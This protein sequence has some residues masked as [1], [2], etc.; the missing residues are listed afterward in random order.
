MDAIDLS[1]LVDSVVTT[2]EGDTTS[3][4]PTNPLDGWDTDKA[5]RKVD[6]EL[7]GKHN[8]PD[9]LAEF[10]RTVSDRVQHLPEVASYASIAHFRAKRLQKL[11]E[12]QGTVLG[13]MVSNLERVISAL[14]DGPRKLRLQ[15]LLY[16][17]AGVFY[18]AIGNFDL[19]AHMHRRSATIAECFGDKAGSAIGQFNGELCQLREDVAD[20][21]ATSVLEDTYSHLKEAFD[22]LRQAVAGTPMELRWGRANAP[23]LMLQ[24]IVWLNAIDPGL[25]WWDAAGCDQWFESFFG[26][27]SELGD[28][29][30]DAVRLVSALDNTYKNSDEADNALSLIINSNAA[31]EIR[32]TASLAIIWHR[33]R[34]GQDVQPALKTLLDMPSGVKHVKAAANCLLNRN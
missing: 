13:Q 25:A 15:S 32:A 4:D 27:C 2:A 29:F 31:L 10:A 3:P 21:E 30:S 26:A 1:S 18:E 28:A 11:T 6:S 8:R 5:F 7:V 19:A 20:G 33:C 24:S 12:E 34:L 22:A 16:Y 17:N 23:F 9:L 14:A